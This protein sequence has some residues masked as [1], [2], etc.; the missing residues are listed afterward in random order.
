MAL[1]IKGLLQ[2]LG[3]F[4]VD[5]WDKSVSINTNLAIRSEFDGF[6]GDAGSEMNPIGA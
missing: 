6:G 3:S 2:T 1:F 4:N 5:G